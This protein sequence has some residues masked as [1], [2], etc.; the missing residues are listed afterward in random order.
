MERFLAR[1]KREAMEAARN[2]QVSARASASSCGRRTACTYA[3]A[4]ARQPP[5]LARAG[6]SSPTR[7]RRPMEVI[8]KDESTKM[9]RLG[10]SLEDPR[11]HKIS[12]KEKKTEPGNSRCTLPALVPPAGGDCTRGE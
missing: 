3:K 8:Q 5:Q 11:E 7:K 12:P 9:R 10:E 4:Q 2:V 6:D 1:G